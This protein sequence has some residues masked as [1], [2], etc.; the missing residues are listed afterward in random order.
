MTTMAPSVASFATAVRIAMADL[1]EPDRVALLDG[2]ED[3]L[4]E[5][6][7]EN[8]QPL[9][10]VLGSPE[11]YAA[12]LRRSAGITARR[13]TLPPPTIAPPPAPVLSPVRA[14][15]DALAT[16]WWLLR[17]IGVAFGVGV[18]TSRDADALSAFPIVPVLDQLWLGPIVLGASVVVSWWI[19][20]LAFAWRAIATLVAVAG[21]IALSVEVGR[22]PALVENPTGITMT[23]VATTIATFSPPPRIEV[24]NVTGLDIDDAI[25]VLRSLG[26]AIEI[27][28]GTALDAGIVLTQEPAGGTSLD[29]G[30]S[31]KLGV[32]TEL[33]ATT[34]TPPPSS[35]P[36]TV[37]VPPLGTTT[38][39]P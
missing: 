23:T 26:F 28:G 8:E 1:D 36:F 24:P 18:W 13:R 5:I 38:T 17:G 19:R 14:A 9:D 33:S 10:V 4:A 30:S 34:S 35:P 39:G 27:T 37:L 32:T 3:H 15:V 25:A 16:G 20:R 21:L 31:I 2:L 7:E 11:Q 6:V 22:T 29:A 12:E